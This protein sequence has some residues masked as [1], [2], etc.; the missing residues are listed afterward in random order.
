M[1]AIINYEVI[2][3]VKMISSPDPRVSE[4]IIFK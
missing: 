1:E 2:L 4:E 3:T